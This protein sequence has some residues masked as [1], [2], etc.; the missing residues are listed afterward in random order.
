[1]RFLQCH[2]THRPASLAS[3]CHCKAIKGIVCGKTAHMSWQCLKSIMRETLVGCDYVGM[4]SDRAEEG[5]KIHVVT[6]R[7]LMV[8]IALLAAG[9]SQQL[10]R[11]LS[12]VHVEEHLR[13][14]S[15][16]CTE[17]LG[18]RYKICCYCAAN[19]SAPRLA[20]AYFEM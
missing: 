16:V 7:S 2:S 11:G 17:S 14:S 20:T 8:M 10:T 4:T 15:E 3:W 9:R 1:M 12:R 19:D 6:T 13:T 18:P 5:P